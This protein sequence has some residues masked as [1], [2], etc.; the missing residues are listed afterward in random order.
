MKS[1][2]KIND[3]KEQAFKQMLACGK[4]LQE[5]ANSNIEEK[6]LIE[7]NNALKQGIQ[8]NLTAYKLRNLIID[9]NKN[10]ID[11]KTAIKAGSDYKYW[12]Y[13]EQLT[14]LTTNE[15]LKL[16]VKQQKAKA[17]NV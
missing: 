9:I 8:N 17:K 6:E 10:D 7:M 14:N 15:E 5:K 13:I 1:K 16:F 3:L 2:S 11:T 12:Y 4:E